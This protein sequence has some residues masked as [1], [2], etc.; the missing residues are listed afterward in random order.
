MILKGQGNRSAL[1]DWPISETTV[2]ET[3]GFTPVENQFLPD[4]ILETV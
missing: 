1:F 2:I 4:E 3:A